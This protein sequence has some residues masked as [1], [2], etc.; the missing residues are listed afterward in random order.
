[1]TATIVS[2]SIFTFLLPFYF[3]SSRITCLSESIKEKLAFDLHHER[4][5]S[6][7]PHSFTVTIV[8][9]KK[10]VSVNNPFSFFFIII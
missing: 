6:D 7:W 5:A 9:I 3:H 4:G 8:S 1:M 2:G 10:A